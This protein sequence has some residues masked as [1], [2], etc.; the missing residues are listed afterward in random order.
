M[1]ESWR[2]D[3]WTRV[4]LFASGDII[5]IF[6]FIFTRAVFSAVTWWIASPWRCTVLVFHLVAHLFPLTTLYSTHRLF[7]LALLTP[8]WCVSRSRVRRSTSSSLLQ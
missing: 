3:E 8:L 2:A 4:S 7:P 6:N 1:A 5:Y